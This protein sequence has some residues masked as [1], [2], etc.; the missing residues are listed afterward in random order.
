MAPPELRWHVT[1]HATV[2]G[3]QS[4]VL[5]DRA[6]GHQQESSIF[7][8]S[9]FGDITVTKPHR[10]VYLHRA[11]TLPVSSTAAGQASP[12]R[13]AEDTVVRARVILELAV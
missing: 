2:I 3:K 12:S 7:W 10:Q 6:P 4:R 1:A 13:A 11:P 9:C 8:G 5:W